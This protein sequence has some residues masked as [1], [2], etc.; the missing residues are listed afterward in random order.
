V[1]G[2][3]VETGRHDELLAR[4][5]EYARLW[6]IFEGEARERGEAA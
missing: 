3:V 1:E 2:K 5:G 6:R 4:D